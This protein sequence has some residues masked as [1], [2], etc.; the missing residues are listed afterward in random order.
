MREATTY[1]SRTCIYSPTRQLSFFQSHNKGLLFSNN[2][3]CSCRSMSLY[4]RAIRC[5]SASRQCAP[6]EQTCNHTVHTITK[7][8]TEA[9]RQHKRDTTK[10]EK[11][12]KH[13]Q[14]ITN[15]PSKCASSMVPN[16][17]NY[18]HFSNCIHC[19]CRL[20]T[21]RACFEIHSLF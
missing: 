15:T 12:P 18:V 20:S 14:I 3:V 2:A 21:T 1:L 17:E 13:H 6:G 11:G 9:M 4:A 16:T 5:L 19:T 8:E 10:A 7:T